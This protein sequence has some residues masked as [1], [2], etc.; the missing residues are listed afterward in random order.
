MC[1]LTVDDHSPNGGPPRYMLGGEPVVTR[2][3]RPLTDAKGRRSFVTSAGAGPSIGKHI[4]MSY[5]P[6]EHAS[7]GAELGVEYMTERY[8]VTVAS[9]D[10]T[11]VFD[12]ANER[13]RS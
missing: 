10:S 5:L 13:I 12:P 2:A 1:A 7:V 4:L 11:P 6:P 9:A 3:G 8:P